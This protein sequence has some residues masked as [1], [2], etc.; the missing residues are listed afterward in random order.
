M[1]EFCIGVG[2]KTVS[3][4]T[5]CGR[6]STMCERN[7]VWIEGSKASGWTTRCAWETL[8][9]CKPGGRAIHGHDLLG[10]LVET[11]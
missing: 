1:I 4:S 2:Y 3:S 5:V 8:T 11:E 6:G 9:R 7:L 10:D